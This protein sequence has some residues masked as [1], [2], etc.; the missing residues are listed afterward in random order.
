MQRNQSSTT[1]KAQVP[2]RKVVSKEERVALRAARRE[3]AVQQASQTEASAAEATA[4]T[5]SSSATS[6]GK[7]PMDPRLVFGLGLG[8]PT[9]LLAW[10]I[11]DEESPPAKFA[12]LVGFTSSF[13][14]FADQFAKPYTNKLLPDW[15]SMTWH[16]PANFPALH[17]LVLDLE[18]TLVSSTRKTTRCGSISEGTIG[19]L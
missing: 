10:G 3:R 4:G 12:Q 14:S 16:H 13:N 2:P 19:V 6:S 9:V 18:N 17:T 5:S 11:A 7:K 15:E 8:I 1:T